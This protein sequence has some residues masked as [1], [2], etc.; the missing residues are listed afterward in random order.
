MQNFGPP[1]SDTITEGYA[2]TYYPGTTSVAEAQRVVV[3]A[4]QDMQNISF[5]LVAARLSK[6]TG[7]AI[8][9]QGEAVSS[10]QIMVMPI[11]TGV[12]MVMFAMMGGGP[13]RPDGTFQIS[14]LAPG[15]YQ[16]TLRPQNFGPKTDPNAEFGRLDV[17]VS[18]GDVENVLIVTGRGGTVRGHI[19]TDTGTVPP[20]KPSQLRLSTS[21]L[22]QDSIRMSGPPQQPRVN[23]DWTFE[24]PGLMDP[25]RVNAFVEPAAGMWSLKSVNRDG[26]EHIDRGLTVEPGAALEGVELV[27]TDKMTVISGLVT[28]DR[29]R[30]VVNATLLFFPSDRERW[31]FPSRFIRTSRPGTDGRYRMRLIPDDD[32]LVIAVQELETG[33][34][35]DPEF[36]ESVRPS[37]RSFSIREGESKTLDLKLTALP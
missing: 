13:V 14:G 4:A 29:N 23:D 32:Y 15:R 17:T 6:V 36:L 18:G 33:R 11:H 3:R 27:L 37:A 9:S 35:S 2:P 25:S 16:L 7:R 21:P 8:N 10:G 26:T 1:G 19:V 20:F 30:P 5:A 34:A 31:T 22:D 24:L 28:D 12:S